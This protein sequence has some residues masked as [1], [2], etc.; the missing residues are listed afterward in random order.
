MSEL[1]LEAAHRRFSAACFN[2]AWTLIDKPARTPDEDEDMLRLAH[3]SLW[4]WTR[5][6]DCTRT[7][8]SIGYWQLARVYAMVGRA[9]EARRYGE[10][11]LEASRDEEPAL[12][13]FAYEA[14]ARAAAVGGRSEAKHEYLR[15]AAEQAKLVTEEDDRERLLAD[16]GTIG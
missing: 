7:N 6:P 10:R 4:H 12:L 13:G 16:L 14:L 9:D 3:A 2:E 8:L 1:D 15:F 11:C 5:R